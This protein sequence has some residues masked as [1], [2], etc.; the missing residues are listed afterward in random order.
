MQ[1]E[2]IENITILAATFFN[3]R[4]LP[5]INFDGHCLMNINISI[6]KKVIYI[7]IYIY[8]YTKL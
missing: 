5:D 6:N 7:Y 8:I 1:E 4:L 3:H 2:N